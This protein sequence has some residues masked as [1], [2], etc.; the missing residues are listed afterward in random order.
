MKKTNVKMVTFA[1]FI[2]TFMSAIE[3][4]IVSTAMPTIIADLDGLAI[5]SWVVSVFLL[6][7]AVSTPIYGKLA[8]SVGRKPVFLFGIGLFVIGSALCG[9]SHSMVELIT[10]RVLQGLGSGAIQT[11][12]VTV[13][14]DMYDI[15]K[16]AKMLGLTS[17]FWG[18]ASVIAPLLG[19]FI[20]QKLSWHWVFMINV[21]IG[22]LAFL[23]VAF[24]L[25]EDF[26]KNKLRID[27]K[28]SFSLV[29]FLLS[30]MLLLQGLE[31]GFNWTLLLL[32]AI[33]LVSLWAFTKVE[34]TAADPI[35]PFSILKDK[36]FLAVNI[37]QLLVSGVVI[38]FEF[39]I[40]TWLQGINGVS[41]SIA[42][43]AITPSSLLWVCGSFL[44][45]D[46]MGRWGT[47]KYFDASLLLLIGADLAFILIPTY[48][49]FWVFCLIAVFNGIG[50]G[51]IATAS[52]V[53]AQMVVDK[54]Q[55]GVATSFNTL[56]KYLGQTVMMVFYGMTFN[57]VVASGL[58]KQPSLTSE[59]M[60]KIVSPVQAKSLDP[61]V[62]APLREILHSSMRGIYIVSLIALLLSLAFNHIYRQKK[63]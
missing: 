7:T 39:Y 12:G 43:F 9:F 35:I 8:D 38:G 53:R 19:G 24:Y 46:L 15:D 10:F 54:S 6:M 61:A 52:Q 63:D 56:M 31:K 55:V 44:A 37:L 22:L 18:L 30:L 1:V 4:T 14:A 2:T 36:E 50:F 59:M 23:L 60:N 28:G 13:L 26:A 11:A 32:A 33:M 3:G 57:V 48:T 17:G 5:M 49:P 21:P 41:A 25:H 16:R 34:K 40:P 29:I 62:L 45:G 27:L 47:Q 58:K 42:G 20:V 51:S